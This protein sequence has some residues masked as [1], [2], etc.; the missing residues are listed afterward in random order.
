MSWQ[1]FKVSV[2]KALRSR[3]Q[4]AVA[5]RASAVTKERGFIGA[6]RKVKR[7]FSP[8]PVPIK[9]KVSGQRKRR[10]I[11]L[12]IGGLVLL[13]VLARATRQG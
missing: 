9:E 7:P 13:F 2:A 1:K 6:D 10:L 5:P 12:V 3:R 11:L 8:P 4:A